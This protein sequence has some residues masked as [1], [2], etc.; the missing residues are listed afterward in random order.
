MT[1]NKTIMEAVADEE[2]TK[3][4]Q[5]LLVEEQSSS[6]KQEDLD[7]LDLVQLLEKAQG[8]LMLNAKTA[9]DQLTLI[10]AVFN[11]RYKAEEEAEKAEQDDEAAFEFS[12]A[13][14]LTDFNQIFSTAQLARKEE[15]QRI[16]DEKESN[17]RKKEALLAQLEQ[18]VSED[19]TESSIQ[20]VKSIQ[21]E[22]KQI[23]ALPQSKVQGLWD[24]Y[25]KLMDA[26][27]DNH[28]INIELKELDRKK[29]LEAKID[30][31]KKMEA[32]AEEKS[33]KRSFILLN[34]YHDEF[35]HIGPVPKESREGIWNAF[36]AASDKIYELKRTEYDALQAKRTENLKKKELLV[37]KASVLAAVSYDQVKD[38]NA[39]TKAFDE[40]FEAWK[41][42]GP[43]P[44]AKSDAIWSAFKKQRNLFYQH[45]KAYFAELNKGRNEN[46]KKKE[47]LCEKVE[48][49]KDHEDFNST[50]K[51]ILALQ[52]EW[53]A[54]GPV[55]DKVNQAIWKR[56]RAAC[57]HFFDR[58][59]KAFAGQRK[60]EES[61]LKSK[62]ALI[63]EL[64]ALAKLDK[65]EE[66]F[67]ALKKIAASWKVLG[68]VPRKDVKRI[69]K[70][71]EKL[72]DD[73]FKKF[74][75]DKNSLKASEWESYYQQIA[76]GPQGDKRLRDE[77]YKIKKRLTYLNE[78]VQNA[79]RNMSF[80]AKSSNAD[81]L[82]KGVDQKLAKN[83]EQLERLKAELK[84]IQK[85]KR[86]LS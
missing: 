33:L 77:E 31:T 21:K 12:K 85:V 67:E 64:Q 75:K 42:V 70:S 9:V 73:L 11:E 30:L 34:K 1:E 41:K 27:Y 53:K 74:K 47:E 58:K 32:V 45:K 14:L 81:K 5:H 84:V 83:K 76:E 68:Y 39:K 79:E 69:N 52:K 26:F 44:Q 2:S 59:D 78:E 62:E 43:V 18:F 10:Q 71:Y 29:N 8:T 19:E 6:L 36:K 54:V 48:A 63:V 38:W 17:L 4:N 46:L 3:M 40:L 86:T 37:E 82:L 23:K 15:K 20:Q 7:S 35:K 50:T 49:L 60:E 16:E 72:T 61:N 66:V 65:E 13:Q 22:W 56:F 57:N 28:S 51:K 80:F 24:K 25:H 55:P